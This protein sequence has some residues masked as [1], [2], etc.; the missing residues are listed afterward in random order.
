MCSRCGQAGRGAPAV[1]GQLLAG[2]ERVAQRH[3]RHAL[4]EQPAQ[5]ALQRQPRE[6]GHHGAVRQRRQPVALLQLRGR[7]RSVTSMERLFSARERGC[8]KRGSSLLDEDQ[9]GAGAGNGACRAVRSASRAKRHHDRAAC[10]SS[11][12]GHKRILHAP[13]GCCVAQCRLL[14]TPLTT[15]TLTCCPNMRSCAAAIR[16]RDAPELCGRR[17][18]GARCAQRARRPAR[19]PRS[20]PCTPARTARH[21]HITA[22]Q[23]RSH[24]RASPG[25]RTASYPVVALFSL[26]DKQVVTLPRKPIVFNKQL[27][28]FC[29]TGQLEPG[30]GRG[31]LLA[32]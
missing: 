27:A 25:S 28:Q 8:K 12:A 6:A 30:E 3:A 31:T 24:A 23:R 5:V 14:I 19:R 4:R 11:P 18:G 26:L 9:S 10:T 16:Q 20:R 32:F 22:P 1:P 13:C 21:K 2:G 15:E 29:F 17:R 7:A